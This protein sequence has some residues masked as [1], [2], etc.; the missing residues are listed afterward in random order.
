MKISEL[1]AAVGDDNIIVQQLLTDFTA[2]SVGKKGATLTFATDSGFVSEYNK[3]AVLGG[4]PSHIG[5][6]VWI[7]ADKIRAAKSN[8]PSA[9]DEGG[10]RS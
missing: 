4:Q 1:I 3:C 6:V 8:S 10:S 7:P 9:G 5:L 2:G